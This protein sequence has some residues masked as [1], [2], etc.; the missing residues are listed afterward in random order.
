MFGK[1]KKKEEEKIEEEQKKLEEQALKGK[2]EEKEPETARAAPE[3]PDKAQQEPDAGGIEGLKNIGSATSEEKLPEEPKKESAPAKP[4]KKKPA[5]DLD[6]AEPESTEEKTEKPARRKKASPSDL[7]KLKKQIE[8]QKETMKE[9]EK[10]KAD[11]LKKGDELA[12]L[13][14][15]LSG[16]VKE[17]NS[18]PAQQQMQIP[19]MPDI[20]PRL[21]EIEEKTANQIKSL[22]EAIEGMTKKKEEEEKGEEEVAVTMKKMFD[23]RLK[24]LGEKLEDV[25]AKP[26]TP[27]GEGG[28][29]ASGLMA[30]GGGVEL[31]KD[32]DSLKKSMKDLATLVDAFKEEAENRFMALDR[33]IEVLDSIP[34]MEQKME[35]FEKKLGP[36]NVQRLRLLISSAD[37][38]KEEV[39]PVVVKRETE[40]KLEPFSKRLKK[41]EEVNEKVIEKH[42]ELLAELKADRKDINA[43]YKFDDRI[44]KLEEAAK[45]LRQ[46]VVEINT[47]MKELD[48]SQRKEIVDKIKEMFPG[49]LEAEV[50]SV[51]KDFAG[52]FAFVE[53]K[54]QSVENVISEAQNDIAELSALK[55]E[56]DTV[57]DRLDGL[58]EEDERI[59]NRVDALKA[60]DQDLL[61]M[62]EKLQTPKEVITELDN[63]TKDI[64]EIREFFVRRANGLEERIKEIDERAVPTRKLHERVDSIFNNL[65]DLRENQKALEQKFDSEKKEL[66]KIIAQHAEGKR[67]LEEKLKE[68]KARISVMLK[69]FK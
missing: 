35:Q 17:S 59:E 40:E 22:Q 57:E 56:M 2:P 1:G 11:A 20:E 16:E 69:E 60:K 51:R 30:M 23:K 41:V 45:A 50:S 65:A 29:G 36:E 43:L 10:E 15:D 68:Q 37:D 8:T 13:I 14:E 7:Q 26:A 27:G 5:I 48:K 53:D 32:I 44:A 24:E 62:I 64:L 46:S 21:K 39:I 25:K 18:S 6:I 3:E 38:L 28:E 31:R 52:R 61:D 12:T 49:M 63:K 33:E 9:L 4:G 47:A 42:S 19:V 66:Q 54:M 34:D 58:K 67:Q 55:G